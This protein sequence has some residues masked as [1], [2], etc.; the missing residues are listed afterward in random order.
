MDWLSF[1]KSRT[2]IK[3]DIV[4]IQQIFIKDSIWENNIDFVLVTADCEGFDERDWTVNICWIN[5]C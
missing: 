2:S 1:E 5:V 3:L 4:N